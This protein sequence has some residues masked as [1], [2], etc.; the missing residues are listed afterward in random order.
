MFFIR[1]VHIFYIHYTFFNVD[2]IEEYKQCI[3]HEYNV[4][5]L[6]AY[7]IFIFHETNLKVY[8]PTLIFFKIF[9]RCWYLILL[10][11]IKYKTSFKH[12]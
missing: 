4:L 3:F 6:N 12:N 2:F 1:I 7:H 8:L 11:Y 10:K 9:I 5:I